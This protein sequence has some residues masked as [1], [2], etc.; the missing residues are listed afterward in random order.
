MI[1]GAGIALASFL[2]AGEGKRADVVIANNVLA[3]VPDLNGFV[4]GIRTLMKE[5]GLAVIEV[6]Y[7]GDLIDHCE[8]DT[9]YHEHLCYFSIGSLR[10]CFDATTCR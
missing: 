2:G 9:I 3:H 10:P 8:F 7:V 1:E 4:Q 5:D 6:P